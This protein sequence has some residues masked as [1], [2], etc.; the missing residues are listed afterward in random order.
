MSYDLGTA[1]GKVE[2]EYDGD[3][4]TAKA[5]EDIRK[6][7]RSSEDSDK[8][9]K[10]FGESL[11][12]FAS[13]MGKLGKGA[14]VGALGISSLVHGAQ[15]L[16][17]TLATLAPLA[18][19]A[20]GALPGL[21]LAAGAAFGV[22]KV[23]TLGLGDAIKASG[24]P[25]EKFE[26][27]IENMSPQA[28][29]LAWGIRGMVEQLKPL[30]N[31]IQDAFVDGMAAMLPRVS[32][33]LLSLQ[34]QTVGVA[35]A[36]GDLV[37]E[38]LGAA[39][40]AK[41]IEN[42]R[43]ALSGVNGFLLQL[44]GNLKPLVDG[45][46]SL[47][48]QASQFASGLGASV[49]GALASL[50]EKMQNFDLAKAFNDAMVVLRPLGEIISNIGSIVKSVFGGLT[51]DAGGALGVI[52]ELTGQLAAFLKSAQGQE[53]LQALGQ[54]MATISGATGQVFLTLLQELAPVIVA[55]A[56]GL[57]E[58][59]LQLSSVLVPALQAAGPILTSIAGFLSDNM[60]VVGPLV[61]ALSGLAAA[62][63]VYAA[64]AKAAAAATAI[65]NGI[66]KVAS[67]ATKVWTGI[68]AAFN[69]VMS[70]NPVGLIIIAIGALIAIIIL[71]ATK[72]DWFQR[73]WKVVWTAIKD[74]AK[75]VADWFMQTLWPTMKAVWDGIMEAVQAAWGVIKKVF[76]LWLSG[77]Q[78]WWGVIKGVLGFFSSAFKAAFDLVASIISTAWTIVSAIFEVWKTVM[79]AIWKPVLDAV[80]GVFKWAWNTITGIITGFVNWITPY[81]K[82]AWDAVTGALKAAW[83]A[84]VGAVKAAWNAVKDAVLAFWNWMKPYVTAAANTVKAALDAAWNAIKTAFTTIWNAIKT[85][86]STAWNAI[87]SIAR[88]SVNNVTSIFNGIRAIVDKVKGFFNDLKNAASG[89][90][91]SLVAFVKTIPGKVIGALGNLGSK[92]YEKGRELV[93]G[94]IDGIGSMV[95]AA[96]NK[97][98]GLVNA[99]TDWLPGSPAKKGPLSGHGWTPWRGKA[100]VEGFA[101]GMERNISLVQNVG[102]K[103]AQAALP[104]APTAVGTATAGAAMAPTV[105]VAA[106]A[107]PVEAGNVTIENLSVVL[108]GIWD[109][110]DPNTS[111]QIA[112]RIHEAI[113]Q[114][115]KG[116]R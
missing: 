115:K 62:V 34:A 51:V 3:R 23:A 40:S 79:A 80:V 88:T 6:I 110:T 59:A 30:K 61:I 27:A 19:A 48:A 21:A 104:V 18:T 94:F 71:I 24:G 9:V 75:A 31:A 32:Q 14:A 26:K 60:D 68:Q 112:V 72:T 84:I 116:Y 66:T 20:I 83:D 89:G 108:Q 28:Q 97:V 78:A 7:G 56:P 76:D 87:V 96:V 54:A 44:R 17:G 90:T 12:K 42:L 37:K 25:L 99:V 64:G 13:F 10:S 55:L 81:L 69:V 52:G 2:I 36:M 91:G 16:A 95:S 105:K 46:I 11:D 33:G 67:A 49:G 86:M 5:D 74:A 39:T 73:L 22:W 111:R 41:N 107:V 106:P 109:M 1:H 15:L 57:A 53:A 93:R 47:G 113:E 82:A 92:L 43:L 58:L 98:K 63:K 102:T 50:G 35:G 77:V 29:K 103:V 4:E 70:L 8:K 85:A 65:W 100:L 38:I 101:Q 114:V 45:F